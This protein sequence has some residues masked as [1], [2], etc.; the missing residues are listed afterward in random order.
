MSLTYKKI[1]LLDRFLANFWKIFPNLRAIN[2]DAAVEVVKEELNNK[3]IQPYIDNS[4]EF[5][6]LLKNNI[7]K[8]NTT[9]DDIIGRGGGGIIYI[10]KIIEDDKIENI[11]G[12][13]ISRSIKGNFF[14]FYVPIVLKVGLQPIN[15]NKNNFAITLTNIGKPISQENPIIFQVPDP[16]SEIIFGAMIGSLYDAGLTPGFLKY[17]GS[18]GCKSDKPFDYNISI[19]SEKSSFPIK[20]LLERKEDGKDLHIEPNTLLNLLFQYVYIIYIGKKYLGLTHFDTHCNNIMITYIHDKVYKFPKE[21][22]PYV[23]HGKDMTKVKYILFKCPSL[24]NTYIVIKNEGLMVKLIDYGVCS[25]FINHSLSPTIGEMFDVDGKTPL[26]NNFIITTKLDHLSDNTLQAKSGGETT[27]IYAFNNA[28]KNNT[29]RN[30][31]DIQFL[32]NNI[33]EFITK[34]IDTIHN[35]DVEINP[36]KD[37][38]DYKRY[39]KKSR[40]NF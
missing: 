30:T 6:D 40:K 32:L 7:I 35:Q 2:S 12:I 3:V 21:V 10:M 39:F 27:P 14:P 29:K 26:K 20:Y 24:T 18:Y 23:Y 33:S 8:I 19:I 22:T 36:I 16:I 38:E 11:M 25:A 34:G 13:I 15:L 28:I 37:I 5:C 1:D 31:V 17:F 9:K 4:L